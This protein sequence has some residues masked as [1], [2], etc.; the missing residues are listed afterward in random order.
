MRF[1]R[2]KLPFLFSFPFGSAGLPAALRPFSRSSALLCSL[3]DFSYPAA[4]LP[5]SWR[6]QLCSQQQL[7]QPRHESGASPNFV[8][9]RENTL[10]LPA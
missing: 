4:S 1:S 7:A 9:L 8:D 2:T 6:S 3:D 10:F 5:S